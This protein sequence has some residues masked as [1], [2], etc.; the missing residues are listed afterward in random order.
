MVEN[1]F[2]CVAQILFLGNTVRSGIEFILFTKYSIKWMLS[3][4]EQEKQYRTELD[5]ILVI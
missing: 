2:G 3:I 4:N 1:L 5:F